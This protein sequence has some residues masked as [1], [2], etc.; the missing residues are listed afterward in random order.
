MCLIT[1]ANFDA[2][3]R[4]TPTE[5]AVLRSCLDM[6][7]LTDLAAGRDSPPQS[8]I[9]ASTLLLISYG[10]GLDNPATSQPLT[11]FQL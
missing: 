11:F 5:E 10:A 2:Y 7:A 3:H 6:H 8:V 1:L 9:L 4:S